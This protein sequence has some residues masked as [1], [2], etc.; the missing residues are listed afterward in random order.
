VLALVFVQFRSA[1]W[2]AL[3]VL[4]VTTGLLMGAGTMW[5]AGMKLNYLSA[6]FFPVIAGI[7]VDDGI[8]IVHRFRAAKSSGEPPS[9]LL[10]IVLAEAGVGVVLTSLTT[11]A[12]FGSLALAS[13]P[14]LASLG[15]TISIGVGTCLAASLFFLPAVMIAAANGKNLDRPASE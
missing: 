1:G 3:A 13:N 15:W 10:R 9:M 7:G 12:G 6:A 5:L 8:H 11:I 4:P 2:T 14:L